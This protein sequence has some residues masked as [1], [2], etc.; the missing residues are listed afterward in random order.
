MSKLKRI[1]Q[2]SVDEAV[3]ESAEYFIKSDFNKVQLIALSYNIP[4]VKVSNIESAQAF[5]NDDGGY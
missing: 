5:L 4:S 1:V 2:Y 3:S